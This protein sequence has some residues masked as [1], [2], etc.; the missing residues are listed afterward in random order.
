[1]ILDDI[2]AVSVREEVFADHC[3]RADDI[4]SRSV[5]MDPRQ[6]SYYRNKFGRVATNSPWKTIDYWRW[7]RRPN[8]NDYECA[9][10]KL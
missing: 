6:T 3:R 9:A 7:I 8:L 1:M 2:G 10:I 5:W 4:L